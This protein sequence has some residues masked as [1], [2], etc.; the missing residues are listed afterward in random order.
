MARIFTLPVSTCDF[1]S[2]MPDTITCTRFSARSAS[3]L[4][5][6]LYGI[7]VMVT[8][9]VLRKLSNVISVVPGVGTR[10]SLPGS[11]RASA[12]SSSSELTLSAVGTDTAMIVL[13][14][15]ASGTRSLGS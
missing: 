14:T 9:D 8:P 13:D 6:S 7:F 12:T 15:R 4:V 10:F 2:A 5:T 11:L 1:T 3:A